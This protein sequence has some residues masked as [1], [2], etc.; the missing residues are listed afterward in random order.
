MMLGRVGVGILAAAL[1]WTTV[2]GCGASDPGK[3]QG[4]AGPNRVTELENGLRAKP[5]FEAAHDEYAAAMTQMADQI[6]ALVPGMTYQ[7]KEDSWSAC[8]G[9]LVSTRGVQVYYY[10]VFDRSIPDDVWPRAVDI[11]KAGAARF[12]AVNVATFVDK[13]GSKDLA[14]TGPD[15]V[16]FEFGTAVQTIFSAKSDCR[17]RATDTAAPS[18]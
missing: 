13:P 17:M 5:S 9:E 10:I 18:K 8:G 12:G 3:Q 1:L 4:N 16:Q 14:L 11:V 6:A 15:G 2:V 7:V